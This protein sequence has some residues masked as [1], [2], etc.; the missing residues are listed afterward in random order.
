M[1]KEHP[2]LRR[3]QL[4]KD[5]KI[6]NKIVKAFDGKRDVRLVLSIFKKECKNLTH[7]RYWETLRSIWIMCGHLPDVQE[8]KEWFN[9][10]RPNK[11]FFSTIEE[12]EHLASLPDRVT[13]YRAGSTADH[14]ISWTTDRKFAYWYKKRHDCA[15]VKKKVIDKSQIFAFVDNSQSEILILE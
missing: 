14:G 7:S 11:S 6:R 9:L 1:Y 3:K 15:G 12:D 8:F 4:L 13:V 2:A 10:T 5:R